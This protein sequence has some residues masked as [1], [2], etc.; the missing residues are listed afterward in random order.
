MRI[1]CDFVMRGSSTALAKL[2]FMAIA[3]RVNWGAIVKEAFAAGITGGIFLD[4]YLY[5]TTIAPHQG[6]MFAV[7]QFI[8]SVA[9]GKVAFSSMSYAWL[10][11]L[12]H[13]AVSIGWAGG[14]AYL[15]SRRRFMNERWAISGLVYGIVVYMF[16]QIILLGANALKPPATPNDFLNAVV[17]HSVFFGLPVA[18]VVA[19]L[20]R[21]TFAQ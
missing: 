20:N 16:M 9:I 8:A 6:S 15:A 19:R 1:D 11:L 13:F 17:A 14:Y 7:W 21:S 10:G 12:I 18:F 3:Q 2:A 5:V 4:L